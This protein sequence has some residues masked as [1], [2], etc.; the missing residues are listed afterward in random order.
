M[1][2]TT[3]TPRC[4]ASPATCAKCSRCVRS[5]VIKGGR[6]INS[7]LVEGRGVLR[8]ACFACRAV[9][10]VAHSPRSNQ[11]TLAVHP[12][13]NRL[14]TNISQT[15]SQ[16][17]DGTLYEQCRLE[18]EQSEAASAS[19]EAQRAQEWAGLQQLAIS[20]A[21]KK[22]LPE[23]AAIGGDGSGRLTSPIIRQRSGRG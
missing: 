19:K 22:G 5:G 20:T 4:T 23:S 12:Q 18:Y 14:T 7:D 6:F 8:A 21:H 3:G 9:H 13:T 10:S 17:L 16:E 11:L 1:P 15:P 2:T